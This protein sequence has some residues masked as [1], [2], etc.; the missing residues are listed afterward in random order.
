M[1]SLIMLICVWN[2]SW[3]NNGDAGD[4]PSQRPVTRSF[5]VFF[6]LHLNKKL[7]KQS[8]RWWFET[9][10]RPL[11]RHCNGSVGVLVGHLADI[12]SYCAVCY[13]HFISQLVC[14]VT[15]CTIV[16]QLL[17]TTVTLLLPSS[18][19]MR[20]CLW[21]LGIRILFLYR[22][23]ASIE[24][25][26]YFYLALFSTCCNPKYGV[27]LK[28]K[29]CSLFVLNLAQYVRMLDWVYWK[30]LDHDSRVF[31]FHSSLWGQGSTLIF[32]PTWE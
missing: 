15:D 5:D 32:S 1:F 31:W 26:L 29:T 16:S 12:I 9:L 25:L 27:K 23:E 14:F 2:N 7:S 19:I 18:R 8:I 10:L 20:H 11:W 13:K 22:S 17:M 6:D 24:W 28:K 4:F 3:V 21:C 30:A